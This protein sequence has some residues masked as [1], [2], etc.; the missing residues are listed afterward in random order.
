MAALSAADGLR[1]AP[2]EQYAFLRVIGKGSYGK[3]Y[4]ARRRD[5]ARCRSSVASSAADSLLAIK[6]IPIES[7]DLDELH[8]DGGDGSSEDPPRDRSIASLSTLKKDRYDKEQSEI[9]ALRACVGESPHT[10]HFAHLTHPVFP[11][12]DRILFLNVQTRRGSSGCSA[13]TSSAARSGWLPSFARPDPYLTS[14]RY[15]GG[16]S[17][18]RSSRRPPPRH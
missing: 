1:T 6:V 17:M 11:M 10:T 16:R 18:S 4:T 15:S 14:C 9:S 13:R 3:V 12:H 7:D 8:D 5:T 2:R